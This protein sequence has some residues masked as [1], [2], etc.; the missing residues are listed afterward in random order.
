MWQIQGL[1]RQEFGMGWRGGGG[2]GDM[3][4]CRPFQSVWAADVLAIFLRKKIVQGGYVP[5]PHGSAS[6]FTGHYK[7]FFVM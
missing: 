1:S 7:T 5:G 2:G 6:V 4:L 3:W